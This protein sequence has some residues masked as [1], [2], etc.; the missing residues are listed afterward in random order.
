M[1]GLVTG[2]QR[3]KQ[4]GARVRA[5][6]ASVFE[7][8]VILLMLNL[9]LGGLWA[10]LATVPYAILAPIILIICLVGAYSTRNS[11]FDVWICALFGMLG[12]IMRTRGWPLA[13]L[14]IAFV[15]GPMI[16]RAGR[17]VIAVSPDLLLH[18][19]AF[20]FFIALGVVVVWLSLRY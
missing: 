15:L 4:Q 7:G 17:Q 6:L 12:W 19:P 5:Q 9:P 18:R 16:E 14:V 2:T 1:N 8:I 13:P 11:M 3:I 20:C 10:R